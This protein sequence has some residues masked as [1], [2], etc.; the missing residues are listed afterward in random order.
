[1]C[2][3]L[4]LAVFMYET[5]KARA[6]SNVHNP[7][8]EAINIERDNSYALDK[9]GRDS[10]YRYFLSNDLWGWVM[11]LAALLSQVRMSY[12]FIVGSEYDLSS[13]QTDLVHIHLEVS[14]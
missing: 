10:V 7:A 6:Q 9:I 8:A 13:D 5:Y 11:A 2:V 3:V 14:L 12:L 1:M 4:N